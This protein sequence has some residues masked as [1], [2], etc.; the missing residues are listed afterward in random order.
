MIFTVSAYFRRRNQRAA[1]AAKVK[2][3]Q[4]GSEAAYGSSPSAG[5]PPFD[6]P[7]Y[8]PPAHGDLN[9]LYN[10]DPTTGFAKVR[11]SRHVNLAC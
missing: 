3:T 5:G 2:Q 1:L 11:S 4:R 7:Q 8:P 9:S 6:P 10:Y